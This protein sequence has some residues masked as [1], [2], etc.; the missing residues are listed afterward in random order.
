MPLIER[1]RVA[2]R[3]QQHCKSKG[4]FNKYAKE[5]GFKN[6]L[7]FVDDGYSG[8]NFNRPSWNELLERIENGEVSALI[9]KDMSRLGRDYLKVGFYTE[10][11]FVEKGVRF[12]AINNGI[13]SANQTDS[14]FTPFLN[15]INEWYAKDT[16]KKIRAVMKSKGE[17]GEHLC[18]NPPYGYMKD[19]D[20]KKHWIV[21]VEA[22]EGVKRI[23]ALCL[24]GYGPTQGVLAH[25]RLVI[26][27]VANHE[28]QFRQAMGAKQKA[29][30]KKELAAKRRQNTSRRHAE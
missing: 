26:S 22:A 16:S 19:A 29:E 20:N 14:D 15:I 25:L 13:D 17:A 28:E 6:T 23:F 21:D 24:E 4:D 18:T 8:T 11:L 27:C 1:R 5:N 3:Q 30:A 10:V 12:I 2:G 9:V 7:F